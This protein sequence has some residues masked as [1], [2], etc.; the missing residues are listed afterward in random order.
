M[1]STADSARRLKA[2]SMI[3]FKSRH[4]ISIVITILRF[5]NLAAKLGLTLYMGRYLSL[6]DIGTYGLVF[7]AVMILTIVLG[8]RFDYIV[9]RDLVRV[10]QTIAILKIRDQTIFYAI[11]YFVAALIVVLAINTGVTGLS[12]RVLLYVLA[13]A[14]TNSCVDFTYINMNSMERPLVANALFF[15]AGGSWCFV[16]IGLGVVVPIFRTVDT[17][18]TAWCVGNLVCVAATFWVLRQM[19]WREV[20]GTPI[21]WAWIREGIQKSF[22]IWIGMLGLSAGSYIDRFVLMHFL[23]LEEVGIATFYFSLA[24]AVLTLVQATVLSSAYPRLVASHREGH[25]DIFQR[26]VRQATKNVLIFAS[27]F[28][29]GIGLAVPLLGSLFERPEFLEYAPVLWMIIVG[30]WIRAHAETLY[31][32]LFAKQQD[33]A[34]WLGNVLYLL[35]AL[36][37]TSIFVWLFGFNGIGYGAI[38]SSLFIYLW[39]AWK[40]QTSLS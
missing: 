7:G 38:V 26:E 16:A 3:A 37:A 20:S 8:F 9:S 19:P 5:A 12:S 36:A 18:L 13:L 28:A 17:V 33:R 21:N 39:R 4:A 10:P 22:L 6:S 40:V 32:V 35:P 15:I 27:V 1:Y 11:N 24:S 29:T 23:G 2:C 34:I 30:V 14:I 25:R 31:Q